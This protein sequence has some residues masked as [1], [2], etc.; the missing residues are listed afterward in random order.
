VIPVAPS[1]GFGLG[2]EAPVPADLGVFGLKVGSG[3][4]GVCP[5]TGGGRPCISSLQKESDGI[6]IPPWTYQ[7]EGGYGREV[8]ASKGEPKKIAE[9][10]QDL[11]SVIAAYPGG[12]VAETKLDGRYV[13]AEFRV[14]GSFPGSPASVDDVEFLLEPEGT[15]DPPALVNYRS[16]SRPASGGDNKR[17][18]QRIKELRLALQ[19]KGWSSIGR[20]IT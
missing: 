5:S 12:T 20:I 7:P 4:L 3:K 6:Y 19:E 11:N 10:I 2:E 8:K 1:F 15:S 13:R 16:A 17:H 14:A 9:A 18:R